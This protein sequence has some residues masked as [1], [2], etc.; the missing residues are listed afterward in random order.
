MNRSKHHKFV[1]EPKRNSK[2]P[3]FISLAYYTTLRKTTRG[4]QMVKKKG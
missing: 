1:G 3:T 4:K 2:V